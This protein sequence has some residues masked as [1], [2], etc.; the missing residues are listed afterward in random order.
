M[1]FL[2]EPHRIVIRN[3]AEEL[4][5]LV[6]RNIELTSQYPIECLV[7]P[8]DKLKC[9]GLIIAIGDYI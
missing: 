9:R 1:D 7:Y 5:K 8:W 4:E 3:N 6:R 2:K